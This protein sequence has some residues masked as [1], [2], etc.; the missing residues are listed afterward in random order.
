[1]AVDG[2]LACAI[3]WL[4][5]AAGHDPALP[6]GALARLGAV[7]FQP[8][9]ILLGVRFTAD[10]RAVVAIDGNTNVVRWTYPSGRTEA[11]KCPE[12]DDIRFEAISPDGAAVLNPLGNGDRVAVLDVVSG[13]ERF[14]ADLGRARLASHAWS[15]DSRWMVLH[16][17]AGMVRVIDARNGTVRSMWSLPGKPTALLCA[18]DGRTVYA[19]LDGTVRAFDGRMGKAAYMFESRPGELRPSGLGFQSEMSLSADG[20]WLAWIGNGVRVWGTTT[21]KLRHVLRSSGK[22]VSYTSVAFS[23][24]GRFVAAAGDDQVVYVWDAET[25]RERSAIKGSSHYVVAMA[26]SPDGRRLACTD[27]CYRVRLLDPLTGHDLFDP[28][29]HRLWIGGVAEL[30]DGRLATISTDETLR[31]WDPLTGRPRGRFAFDQPVYQ[32]TTVD[33]GRSLLLSGSFSGVLHWR[34]DRPVETRRW[35]APN[36]EVWSRVLSP[37][38]RRIA[39]TSKDGAVRLL[40][41]GT[42]RELVLLAP[43]GPTPDFRFSADS[44]RLVIVRGPDQGC[45][46]QVLALPDGRTVYRSPDPTAKGQGVVQAVLNPSGDLL[47]VAREDGTVSLVALRTGQTRYR[48]ALPAGDRIGVMEWSPDGRL[49]VIG[50]ASGTVFVWDAWADALSGP[51]RGHTD[52]VGTVA[53]VAAG[54]RFVT[55][56]ADTTAVVWDA[57]T[58]RRCVP[59]SPSFERCWNNLAR[60][61]GIEVLTAMRTLT[62]AGPEGAAFLR[63]KL[64]EPP[65][66]KEQVKRWVRDLDSARFA[67]RETATR[68]LIAVGDPIRL[69]L[70]AARGTTASA[71]VRLRIDAVLAAL[72]GDC[73]RHERAREILEPSR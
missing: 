42:G 15:P 70:Q 26:F 27:G 73:L 56:S 69:T 34:P 55:G 16:D 45:V 49:L 50:T 61:E 41:A 11:V 51:L 37:D 58:F 9:C 47:T 8:K 28:I 57:T 29:G 38:G 5:P 3:V 59:P 18:P 7:A 17:T 23:P 19:L 20:R 2:L 4:F 25:G 67:T 44:R 30:A 10:G 52:S 22:A 71:E 12:L 60:S 6:P 32:F 54:A 63:R 66:S 64:T 39:A 62:D 48:V 24:D 1:M 35:P 14:S 72:E 33:A 36:Q 68:D 53:F 65:P 13:R 46:V 21:G 40:D 31:L 43:P